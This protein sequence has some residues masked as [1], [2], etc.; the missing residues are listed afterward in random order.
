MKVSLNSVLEFNKRYNT[1]SDVAAI[2]TDNLIEKIGT[3]LGGIDEVIQ[4]CDRQSGGVHKAS[5]RR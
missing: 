3:Q 2:G 5:Q 1:T 4:L